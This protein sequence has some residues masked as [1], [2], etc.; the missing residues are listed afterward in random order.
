MSKTLI[1]AEKA[2][3]L[4]G[5]NRQTVY[6][7]VRRGQLPFYR[8]GKRLI[9]FDEE[10]LLAWF[11]MERCV[12]ASQKTQRVELGAHPLTEPFRT[13]ERD[14]SP[15]AKKRRERYRTMLGVVK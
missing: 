2:A 15:E 7:W 4:L 3:E 6:L 10:E 14:E 1:T 8:V 11:K 9:K 12:T 5:V 13:L